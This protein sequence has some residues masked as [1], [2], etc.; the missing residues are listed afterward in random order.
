[1]IEVV[2]EFCICFSSATVLSVGFTSTCSSAFTDRV[3]KLV[4]ATPA[5][6][7]RVIFYSFCFF[8]ISFLPT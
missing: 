6:K 1:V 7:A 3:E 5:A 2:G 8:L 4:K